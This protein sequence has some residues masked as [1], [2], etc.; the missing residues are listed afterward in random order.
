MSVG[1]GAIDPHAG[2]QQTNR[3][4]FCCFKNGAEN[5][6]FVLLVNA[7][8]VAVVLAAAGCSWGRQTGW[9]GRR[10]GLIVVGKGV[11]RKLGCPIV[12]PVRGQPHVFEIGVLVGVVE[13]NKVEAGTVIIKTEIAPESSCLRERWSLAVV[14][15]VVFD[16]VGRRERRQCRVVADRHLKFQH[17][18]ITTNRVKREIAI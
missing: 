11:G 1:V 18:V 17:R 14:V 8:N 4:L 3:K 13:V 7:R 5:A 10:N 12:S 6:V 9:I 16:F 15:L 2:A